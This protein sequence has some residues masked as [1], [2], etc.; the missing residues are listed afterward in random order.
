MRGRSPRHSARSRRHRGN[1]APRTRI[2]RPRQPAA[3]P[4]KPTGRA[5]GSVSPGKGIIVH[6]PC[7]PRGMGGYW[8]SSGLRVD[9]GSRHTS[10]VT[11]EVILVR[12]AE[13]LLPEP[14]GPDDFQR[15]LTDQGRRQAEQLVADLIAFQPVAVVSSPYLRAVQTVAPVARCLG[16]SVTLRT[17][18]REW[19]SGLEPRPDFAEHYARSWAQPTTSRPGGESLAHLSERAMQA[20]WALTRDFA[21][22]AVVVGS[23]G[24]FIARALAGFG[25]AVDWPFSR[26]MPMPAIYRLSLGSTIHAEGPGL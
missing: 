24:T 1:L 23:H 10:R 21:G 8:T 2:A 13:P 14:N 12:H 5:S 16:M 22:C 11:C 7:T 15:G 9:R 25:I 18:L 4:L 3:E 19:D 17:E 26:A 20:L 6:D